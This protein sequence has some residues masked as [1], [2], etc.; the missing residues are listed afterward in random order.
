MK[1]AQPGLE[2]PVCC[3]PGQSCL[4][5]SAGIQISTSLPLSVHVRV[6]A[7][8]RVCTRVH[9]CMETFHLQGRCSQ[10]LCP[11]PSPSALRP[12]LHA[13]SWVPCADTV[14]HR[15]CRD[16]Q[17]EREAE[18]GHTGRRGLCP[19]PEG[20]LRG[21]SSRLS[22]GTLTSRWSVGLIHASDH[23]HPPSLLSH[24]I[25]PSPP[26]SCPS[27]LPPSPAKPYPAVVIR[28]RYVPG[29]A[30]RVGAGADAALLRA[31][32]V[33]YSIGPEGNL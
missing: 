5:D 13:P 7:P 8:V 22:L 4:S 25:S 12:A 24:F 14:G 20:L 15:C 31:R 30:L 23:L 1:R 27:V 16:A 3:G 9:T 6:C 18:G 29:A 21:T 2:R 10:V 26:Q 33:K 19:H 28:R 11:C 32:G 17:V